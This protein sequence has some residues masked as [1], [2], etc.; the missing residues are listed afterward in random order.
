LVTN[1][2]IQDYSASTC[3]SDK[4]ACEIKSMCSID[5]HV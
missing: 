4:A 3:K 2:N 1:T 5:W